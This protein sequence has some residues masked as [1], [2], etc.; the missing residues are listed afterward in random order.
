MQ[1]T[2][3]ALTANGPVSIGVQ[4]TDSAGTSG[5]IVPFSFV[6]QT[7]NLG[8][9]TPPTPPT[10]ALQASDDSSGGHD[11]TNVTQ[12]HLIGVTSSNA[13]VSLLDAAGNIVP[14]VNPLNPT[15]PAVT[16][17]TANSTTG[18]FSLQPFSPLN[19]N[20]ATV[21]EYRAEATNSN[22]SAF[23]SFVTFTVESVGPS[24][25]IFQG[26]AL[27]N[28]TG[29]QG[30][31]I[32]SDRQPDFVG[33][34]NPNAEVD[35]INATTGAVLA[36]TTA[37]GSGAYTIQLPQNLTDGTIELETK[38]HDAAG[39]QGP[40]STVQTVTIA[41]VLGDYTGDGQ[42]DLALYQRTSATT[43]TWFI[44]GVTSSSGVV[45]GAGGADIPLTGDFNGDGISDL[46]FYQPSN[47]TFTIQLSGGG[48]LEGGSLESIPLGQTGDIP[49]VG[50]FD[51]AGNSE[52]GV[53]NP[54]TNIWTI[55]GVNGI[56]TFQFG[57][58]G[59][60]P[61]AGNYDGT[62]KD[63][64]ALYRPSTGQFL[65][66]G[67]TSTSTTTNGVTRITNP[68]SIIVGSPNEVPDPA[69]YDNSFYFQ[70]GVAE[71]T[72]PAVYNP[73][74][75]Q[76]TIFKYTVPLSSGT[77]TVGGITYSSPNG[78]AYNVQFNPGD[79]IA[80]GDY[81]GTGNAEPAVYRPGTAQFIVDGATGT[82]QYGQTG[83][84]PVLA[85]YFYRQL[86]TV[87]ATPT[88]ALNPKDDTSHGQDITNVT[89]PR[90]TGVTSAGA[91][92]SLINVSTGSVIG[93]GFA[94]TNGNYSVIP[95]NPLTDGTYQLE[96]KASGLNN[97]TL[98][99]KVLTLTIDTSLKV[100]SISPANNSFNSGL[101]QVVV[102]FNHPLAGLTP[103][104]PTGNGFSS[105]PYSVFLSPE[106][107]SG[108]FSAPSGIDSGNVPL[109]GTLVYHVNSDGTSQITLTPTVP[110]GTDIYL[111]EI[112]NLT[113]LAGNAAPEQ[114]RA[115]GRRTSRRSRSGPRRSTRPPSR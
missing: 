93:S 3:G 29:I 94:D 20:P 60:V 49:V 5:N 21:Y 6:L 9:S 82:V 4:A 35:L 111:I 1:I 109:H 19:G 80:S 55:D 23:S 52:V 100:V 33:T 7:S 98:T 31:N 87:T 30:D 114:R 26:L 108:V 10:L 75:G 27:A 95:T 89:Q 36:S 70:N 91:Q 46:A 41:S 102:V 68:E 99:S 12:P 39:N 86:A 22:G 28:D 32:T 73:N 104:D 43:G 14:L 92:I 62:G 69:G 107:P 24:I 71:R 15:G 101:N 106:G 65:I 85:P 79:I 16:F 47:S 115:S 110:L 38:V 90:V 76:L 51:G 59:D 78:L 58:S 113:D 45:F 88:I 66:A 74:T 34:T 81:D 17:V 67:P 40:V 96:V 53:Y 50:N 103:D 42:A 77:E 97:T 18:A 11:I 25:N 48:Q 84:I 57:Q 64:L 63:E 13:Q 83:D 61:V 56:E 8:A 72:E 112:S 37:D 105:N 44:D 54:T 2:P